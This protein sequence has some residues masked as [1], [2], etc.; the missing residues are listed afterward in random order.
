MRLPPSWKSTRTFSGNG[1][2]LK[3]YTSPALGMDRGGQTVHASLT[4]TVENVP[5][6]STP[7]AFHQAMQ[8][9]L[10]QNF[11][12][13]AHTKWKD[14]FVDQLRTESQVSES[15]GKRF[16][17][18]AD[19]RAYTLAFE[20]RGD[21]YPRVSRWCDMIAAALKVGTEMDAK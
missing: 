8:A 19:G 15:R 17:R 7:E 10:G 13:L 2:L 1:T 6:G 20:A 5:P 12:L 16:Y 21:V 3:Q 18:L 9:K 14:G 4:V 11:Q